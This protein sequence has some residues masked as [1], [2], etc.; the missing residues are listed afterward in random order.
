MRVVDARHWPLGAIEAHI[1]EVKRK[2]SSNIDESEL[3]D[4][5]DEAI[6][7]SE[8]AVASFFNVFG[9]DEI[10]LLA[11]HFLALLVDDADED[12]IEGRLDAG[13]VELKVL[14]DWQCL[15]KDLV[16]GDFGIDKVTKSH[17]SS[18]DSRGGTIEGG[19]HGS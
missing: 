9:V 2:A 11:S 16:S 6:G 1:K 3:E 12:E 13:G 15:K 4:E 19:A 8:I 14:Q 7:Q 17:S 5:E 18:W 10:R